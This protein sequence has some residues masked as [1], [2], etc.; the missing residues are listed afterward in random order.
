MT[1]YT[2]REIAEELGYQDESRPGLVVRKYLRKKYPDHPKN[3]RW[4]LDEA[5]AA[6]VRLNVP[7]RT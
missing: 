6:D 4:I 1:H 2:P 7:R 3:A 5:Q